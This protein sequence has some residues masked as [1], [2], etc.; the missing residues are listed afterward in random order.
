MRRFCCVAITLL[1]FFG[2]VLAQERGP[3]SADD[4]I[5]RGIARYNKGDL[6]GA[7]ADHTKAIALDPKN[8]DAY[9]NRGYAREDNADMDGAL[10]DYTKA[11]ANVSRTEENSSCARAAVQ[12]ALLMPT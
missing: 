9:A 5:N 2:A 4:Y 3:Q 1:A 12:T 6:V 11:I 10:A 8:S 7:I